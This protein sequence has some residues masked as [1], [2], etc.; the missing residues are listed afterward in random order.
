[1]KTL[2]NIKNDLHH[3]FVDGDAKSPQIARI[4]VLLDIPLLL[5]ILVICHFV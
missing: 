1:M 3:V 2:E 5:A 4:L